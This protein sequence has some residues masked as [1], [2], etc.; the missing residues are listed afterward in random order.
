MLKHGLL[1][2]V[3]FGSVMLLWRLLGTDHNDSDG[4]EEYQEVS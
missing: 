2:P 4:D 3:G 1:V